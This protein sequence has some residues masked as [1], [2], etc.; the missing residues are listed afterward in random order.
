MRKFFVTTLL[1]VV[2]AIVV[3]LPA[4]ASNQIRVNFEGVQGVTVWYYTTVFGWQYAGQHDDFC[5]FECPV[6][7]IGWD[8]LWLEKGGMLYEIYGLT[9]EGGLVYDVPMIPLRVLGVSTGSEVYLTQG[10]KLV[11]VQYNVSEGIPC[12]FNVFDNDRMFDVSMWDGSWHNTTSFR[13]VFEGNDEL[14]A[15]FRDKS[16]QIRVNFEGVKGVTVYYFNDGWQIVGQFDDYCE[17]E[18]PGAG[19][20]ALWVGKGNEGNEDA[21][22]YEIS[23]L[24]FEG[25]QVYDV[26]VIPLRVL[27][28]ITGSDVFLTQQGTNVDFQ[29]NV[30]EGSPCLFNVFDNG[31][32]FDV[33]MYDYDDDSWHNTTSFRTVFDG[34]EELQADF[35]SP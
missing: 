3:S 15:D 1:M 7:S 26:P 14:Q 25:G 27:G 32:V 17:F 9:F 24:T 4:F 29:H 8:G 34:N 35:Q 19:S 31:R 16:N 2:M 10:G 20:D 28:V 6:E 30:S 5:E 18:C 23:G 21:M 12:L 13:T 22:I 33:S 11:D